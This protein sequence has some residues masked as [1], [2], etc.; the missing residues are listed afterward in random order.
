MEGLTVKTDVSREEG[1]KFAK[2]VPL[3]VFQKYL[4][5]ICLLLQSL[6]DLEIFCLIFL[7]IQNQTLLFCLNI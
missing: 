4:G 3:L 6:I 2:D 7:S 1:D 5:P